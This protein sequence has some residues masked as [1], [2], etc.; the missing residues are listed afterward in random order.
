MDRGDSHSSGCWPSEQL[1]VGQEEAVPGFL[2]VVG[3]TA[4]WGTG[5]RDG[6]Q[7]LGEERAGHR[8]AALSHQKPHPPALVSQHPIPDFPREAAVEY[9]GRSSL[10]WAG[11]LSV[12]HALPPWAPLRQ[13][14]ETGLRAQDSVLLTE[15]W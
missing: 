12:L 8:T 9:L 13:L 2:V 10:A 7:G 4:D 11:P 3:R 15:G 5:D 14:G 6:E 1:G